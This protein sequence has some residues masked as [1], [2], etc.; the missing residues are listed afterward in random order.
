MAKIRKFFQKWILNNIG[1]K[2]L[3]LIFAFVVWL[4]IMNTTDPVTTRT[5]TGIPVE[6]LNEDKVKD[7]EHVYTIVSG[8]TATIVVSGNRSII[9]A[10][11]AADF[12]ATADFS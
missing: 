8:N 12:R 6:I 4:V 2:I 1:F 9:G 7:G 11:S 3:A 5:I 10:L